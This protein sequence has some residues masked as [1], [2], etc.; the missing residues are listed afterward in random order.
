M[1]KEVCL[2]FSI[3][4]KANNISVLLTFATAEI[5]E[6]RKNFPEAH[7]LFTNLTEQLGQDID[8]LVEIIDKEIII[9]KGPEIPRP[10]GEA[11]DV[12]GEGPEANY[13][14][15]MDEREERGK[16]VEERRGKEVME[17]RTAMG[18]VWIMYMRFARRAEVSFSFPV[19]VD[20]EMKS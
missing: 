8:K 4:T 17:L 12:D 1:S 6:D 15:M 7:S 10:Q 13:N 14:R 20:Q 18:V 3:S 2:V 5:E 11:M 16:I 9:A 19:L